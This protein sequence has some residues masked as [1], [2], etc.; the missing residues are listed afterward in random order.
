MS[1]ISGLGYSTRQTVSIQHTDVLFFFT[2]I[3]G[4]DHVVGCPSVGEHN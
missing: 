4:E 2:S 1:L 3:L